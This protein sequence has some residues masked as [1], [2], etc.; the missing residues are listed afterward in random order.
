MWEIKSAH[1]VNTV[2]R[3][4][5]RLHDLCLS[6]SRR[7]DNPCS[8]SS[9][10]SCQNGGTCM[11]SNTDPPTSSCLCPEGYTG[12][13]CERVIER[14]PCASNPCQTR[15]H[16]ALSTSNRTYT[17]ICQD[18]FVGEQ[19]ER[20]KC[21]TMDADRQRVTSHTQIIRVHRRRASIKRSVNR[22]GTRMVLGIRVAA[23]ERLLELVVK[24]HCSILAE[25]CV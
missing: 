20:S 25:D 8:S 16:C 14:D 7:L 21:V 15:G 10:A 22:V 23:W 11:S 19:C 4:K 17:C 9:N 18:N 13:H 1:S 24:R 12:M 6:L 2:L 3:S 5:E